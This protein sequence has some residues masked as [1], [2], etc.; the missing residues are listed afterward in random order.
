MNRRTM[1]GMLGAMILCVGG[2]PDLARTAD[3][4]QYRGPQRDGASRETG[5]LTNWPAEG[6]EILWTKEVGEGYSAV[7]VAYGR[8]YTMG[9]VGSA[10]DTREKIW[11]L[12]AATGD[13]VWEHAYPAKATQYRG[14]RGTP[15]VD[16]KVVYTYGMN[17][18]LSCLDA[19]SGKVVWQK[20]AQRDL[21]AR[22]PT[23]GYAAS[24]I[25]VQD[26]VVVPVRIVSKDAK[27]LLMAFDK[28]TGE[29]R[30]RFYRESEDLGGGYWSNAVPAVIDGRLC[31][32]YSTGDG[33]LGLDPATGLAQW[34]YQVTEADFR[35]AGKGR[36]CTAQEPVVEG[37]RV[38]FCAHFRFGEGYTIAFDVADKQARE[39]WRS[40]KLGN[41]VTCNVVLNGRLYGIHHPD[42]GAANPLCCFRTDTGA[43][44]WTH[45]GV[46][47]TLTAV[48][49]KLLS[50]DGT[51]LYLGKVSP[52]GYEK[53]AQSQM[54]YGEVR[55][56][57]PLS[58]QI[59]PVLSNGR[60]YCRNMAGQL[61][62]LNTKK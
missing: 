17:G 52:A 23:Y 58:D 55:S 42:V 14:A 5:W 25:V 31:L 32:V 11:R 53:L 61:I 8:V 2:L 15:T 36:G 18:Q 48:D 7:A 13:V 3:W 39:V 46:G 60:V 30:R 27:A 24:P 45:K 22:E 38:F 54:L 62:C 49:G 10:K 9:L 20:G 26:L 50:F 37:N 28:A 41:W 1:G 12:D 59:L 19:G 6:L 47:R 43:L 16:G 51:R 57:N 34:H 40:D 56:K 33:C 4:P 29:E 35:K 21:G 44:Q